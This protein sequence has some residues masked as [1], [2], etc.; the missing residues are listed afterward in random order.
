[1]EIVAEKDRNHNIVWGNQATFRQARST[2]TADS[3]TIRD[4]SWYIAYQMS[5][6]KCYQGVVV[7]FRWDNL[8]TGIPGGLPLQFLRL[9]YFHLFSYELISG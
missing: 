9:K 7:N 8:Q 4:Y 1:M 5:I 3:Y 2:S 6:N